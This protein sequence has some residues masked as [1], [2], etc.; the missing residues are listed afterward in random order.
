MRNI[1][2]ILSVFAI[3]SIITSCATSSISMQVLVPAEITV[4]TTIKKLTFTNRSL[5]GKGEKLNNII[6]GVLTGEGIQVDREAS[7]RCID[8]VADVLLSSPRYTINVPSNLDLRGKGTREWPIP[9]DWNE[10]SRLC[11]E[12]QSDALVTLEIFDSNTDVRYSTREGKKKVNNVEVKFTEHVATMDIGITA[13]WRIYD[14][15]KKDIVDQSIFVDHKFWHGHG[16]SKEQAFSKLPSQRPCVA[17]AGRFAGAQYAKRIS[18]L[19]VWVSRSY[20]VKGNDNFKTAKFKVKANQWTEAAEIWQQNVNNPELKI[21]G[22][23]AYNLALAA[24]VD[25]K[26]DI[27]LEWAKKAYSDYRIKPAKSYITTI[28][29]R[30]NDQARLERQ[31]E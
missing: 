11:N 19:W 18:P 10:V 7:Y 20:Y 8:G 24:E 28:K 31:M 16:E 14:P 25:G 5:P 6:E 2:Y 23:A 22:R 17:D 4:P 21:A 30:I 1:I 13:G 3:Y 27:A 9:L 12:Y 29:G 15:K 26:L